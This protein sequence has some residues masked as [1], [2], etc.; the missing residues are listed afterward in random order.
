MDIIPWTYSDLSWERIAKLAP[1]A[2]RCAEKGDSVSLE[3][4]QKNIDGL[5]KSAVAVHKKMNWG[6]SKFNIVLC[7][8]LMTNESIYQKMMIEGLIKLFPNA[9]ITLPIVS[10]SV[11]AALLAL[12]ISTKSDKK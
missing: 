2:L 4:L 12:K 8:G 1:L 7:G 10:P 6:D 3:I 11:G 9:K 5:L